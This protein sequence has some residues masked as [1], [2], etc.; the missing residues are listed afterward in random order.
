LKIEANFV[1]F[2]RDF[3]WEYEEFY[4]FERGIVEQIGD[5]DRDRL[6]QWEVP[7]CFKEKRCKHCFIKDNCEYYGL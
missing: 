4:N 6:G 5:E 3:F 1:K 2:P 7:F